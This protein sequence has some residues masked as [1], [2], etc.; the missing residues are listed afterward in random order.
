MK[1]DVILMDLQLG[2]DM[3]GIS[4]ARAI[5]TT[6]P[7][8]RVLVLSSF[9][10]KEMVQNALQAGA[11][12]YLVK[13][14]P[15]RELANA[16][17]AAYAGQSTFSAEPLRDLV[18]PPA[19]DQVLGEGLTERER[20]VLVLL[21]EGES[22]A[23]IAEKLVISVAAVKYHVSSILSKLGAANRTEA[24]ALARQ[25]KLLAKNNSHTD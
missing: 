20:Q 22:N 12:G 17:R 15:G 4:T 9:H 1:P 19:R 13:G 18:Q 5:S 24:A 25:H 11:I 7:A 6:Y 2:N 23:T 16:I 3:D 21:V 14:I 10:D 8:V